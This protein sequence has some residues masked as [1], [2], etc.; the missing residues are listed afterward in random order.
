VF[1]HELTRQTILHTI[2]PQRSLSLNR[3]ILTALQASPATRQDLA[4][5]AYHAAASEEGAMVLA[6][7][8]PA[9]QKANEA[10]SKRAAAA[11]Y[12]LAIRYAAA[13][14]LPEQAELHQNYSLV[15]DNLDW[16]PQAI[17]A[18]RHAAHLWREAG[19]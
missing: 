15:C 11:L 16:R 3:R 14:P 5:L 13:L 8:P 1:R 2:P 6:C 12:E 10:G 19:N 4:R 7:A 18:R 9:A 17:T